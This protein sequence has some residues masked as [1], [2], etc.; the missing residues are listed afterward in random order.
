MEALLGHT[1]ENIESYLPKYGFIFTI[2]L[3]YKITSCISKVL[4]LIVLSRLK[5]NQQI[6][7]PKN[8]NH[9]DGLLTCVA[10]IS[11]TMPIIRK[12]I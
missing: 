11:N 7:K 12:F 5:I 3:V 6:V 1:P 10:R 9:F 4:F 2:R 8:M